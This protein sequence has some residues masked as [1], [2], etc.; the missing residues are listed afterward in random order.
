MSCKLETADPGTVHRIGRA[1]N[2]WTFPDWRYAQPNGTFGNRW[3][4]PH[5]V[6]RVSYASSQR[7]GTFVETLSR[8]RPDPK[9]TTWAPP[10]GVIATLA[11][12]TGVGTP[13]PAPG[14]VDVQAW[15]DERMIG[16]AHPLGLFADV[17]H[18]RSLAELTDQ[19]SYLLISYALTE[20]DATVIKSADRDL[21]QQ[22]SKYLFEC[23][24]DLPHRGRQYDGIRYLSRLGDDI[25]NWAIFEP[26][27]LENIHE[28]Q[29]AIDDPDLLAVASDFRLTLV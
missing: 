12:T 24:S 26:I 2:P 25:E 18:S 8:F 4:D 9:I 28:N 11:L 21:T 7:R 13:S 23:A 10:A 16:I 29:I 15:V 5:G 22:I 1:P 19:L 17:D 3:D 14:T 6:Y 27:G 20:F